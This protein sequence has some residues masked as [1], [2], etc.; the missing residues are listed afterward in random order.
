MCNGR[1]KETSIRIAEA[2]E[3]LAS[4]D[5]GNK[6]ISE[7]RISAFQTIEKTKKLVEYY[8]FEHKKEIAGHGPTT[9]QRIADGKPQ[10]Y[11]E[12]ELLKWELR[13]SIIL[14]NLNS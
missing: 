2:L 6:S 10:E 11:F 5:F 13:L 1:N 9:K 4:K 14:E 3:K 8:I 12:D 7:H